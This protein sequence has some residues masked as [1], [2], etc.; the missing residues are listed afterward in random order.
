MSPVVDAH[1]HI[2]RLARAD[3]GWLT[4]ALGAIHRDIDVAAW[5]R[6]AA[7]CGVG[8]GVLVQAAPTAAETRFLLDQAEAHA[9]VAGVVGWTDLLAS[10][11]PARIAALARHPKLKGVRPM[12]HDL[13]DPDW[14]LQAALAPALQAMTD[15]G[16]VFDALVRP[17]HLP[18]ILE[19]ARRHPA[20][21]IV[22]DH[23][24]KPPIAAGHWQPWADDLRR[25]AGETNVQCKLSGLLTE[26]GTA[27]LAPWVDHVFACFGPERVIWGSDWPVL[28]L[29]GDYKH[30]WTLAHELS[31][32][33]DPAQRHAVFGANAARVYRLDGT[34]HERVQP[35]SV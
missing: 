24:A 2:W 3:Y 13:A 6:V 35:G 4:P 12:L 10:D 30:W 21:R 18:R 23:A 31:S 16:L 27:S 26:S 19:L 8:R 7:P 32:S 5:E 17:V 28:E 33:L 15:L 14:I 34:A 20:L 1:F 9:A 22:L 11:A 25:L 29:A